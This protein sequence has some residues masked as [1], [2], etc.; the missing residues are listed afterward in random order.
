MSAEPKD[1][2]SGEPATSPTPARS[3]AWIGILKAGVQA[4]R[5]VPGAVCGGGVCRPSCVGSHRPSFDGLA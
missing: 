5:L 4:Q 1:Q 2:S 3:A